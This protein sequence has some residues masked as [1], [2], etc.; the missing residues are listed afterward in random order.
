MGAP[1]HNT[2]TH[3]QTIHRCQ[4]L[5][6]PLPLHP[7]PL[8]RPPSHV[9]E[10]VSERRDPHCSHQQQLDCELSKAVIIL[11]QSSMKTS[12]TTEV[13]ISRL[14][15][16][17]VQKKDQQKISFLSRLAFCCMEVTS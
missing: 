2:Q 8:L 4:R 7:L 13:Q 10:A 3:P 14:S 12:N 1:A 16:S 11:V 9:F 6:A 15:P 5:H 17:K